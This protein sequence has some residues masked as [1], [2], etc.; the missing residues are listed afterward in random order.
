MNRAVLSWRVESEGPLAYV[1]LSGEFTESSNF[2]P[3]LSELAAP[4]VVLDLERIT[5]INSVGLKEW[6]GFITA[7]K[8]MGKAL[9]LER[10]SVPVVAQLNMVS[11]FSGG[12]EVRTVLAPYLCP[13]CEHSQQRPVVVAS[14]SV[15][16]LEAPVGCP[17][18][19]AQMEFDDLPELFLAFGRT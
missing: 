5:R 19:G 12:A 7:L 13:S 16:E 1:Q 11:N 10:C 9:V 3:L 4:E 2:G 6:L 14:A 15:D 8:R 17:S 18:C